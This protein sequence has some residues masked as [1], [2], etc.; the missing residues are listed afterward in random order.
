R[1]NFGLEKGRWFHIDE[2]IRGLLV[3]DETNHP[4]VYMLT[5]PA[6]HYY[7]GMTRHDRMPVFLGDGI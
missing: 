5:E 1:A 2:G 7:H 4:H 3:N 6:S